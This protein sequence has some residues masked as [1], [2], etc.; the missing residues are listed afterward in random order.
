MVTGRGP[1]GTRP[2][3]GTSEQVYSAIPD[4]AAPGQV[5]E[6][7]VEDAREKPATCVT[8][9]TAPPKETAGSSA[10][11]AQPVAGGSAVRAP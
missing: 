4:L 1:D 7:L 9:V 6:F 8:S 3:I 10:S 11:R 2:V 5:L